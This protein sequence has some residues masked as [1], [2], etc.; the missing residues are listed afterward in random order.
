MC[1]QA[2]TLVNA[3]MTVAAHC[4]LMQQ[5]YQ[6][7]K[8]QFKHCRTKYVFFWGWWYGGLPSWLKFQTTS[9]KGQNFFFPP[10]LPQ[11]SGSPAQDLGPGLRS[12]GPT[13]GKGGCWQP[14]TL[15]YPPRLDTWMSRCRPR[16]TA[17]TAGCM[18]WR[19]PGRCASGMGRQV[20][21]AAAGPG[22]EAVEGA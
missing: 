19:W 14:G 15:P 18:C 8:S 6:Y 22:E 21:G 17:T 11:P 20:E 1:R 3:R 10:L 7:V 9:A 16:P 13:W 4:C 5:A 12:P 2:R